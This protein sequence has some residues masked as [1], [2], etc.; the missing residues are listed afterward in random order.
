MPT[1]VC[2][3]RT[4]S[5]TATPRIS[6][7][8]P[9][10]ENTSTTTAR[11]NKRKQTLPVPDDSSTP[12]KRSAQ[13]TL[14]AN[15]HAQSQVA[16]RN[17]IEDRSTKRAKQLT[18]ESVLVVTG[19]SLPMRTLP[20]PELK[21]NSGC[22]CVVKTPE[23]VAVASVESVKAGANKRGETETDDAKQLELSIPENTRSS[24][25]VRSDR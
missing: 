17:L 9:E 11:R 12:R 14:M 5:R 4:S 8:Q 25:V 13:F 22:A 21:I 16:N 3:R 2:V 19:S 20:A 15:S 23:Q 24:A 18:D 10:K 6:S 1:D 7:T